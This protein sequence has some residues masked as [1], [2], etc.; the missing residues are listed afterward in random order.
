MAGFYFT[1]EC[2]T[3]DGQTRAHYKS[4][5]A[6]NA[7]FLVLAALGQKKREKGMR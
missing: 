4:L 3:S 7:I 5:V 2:F 1:K 6:L